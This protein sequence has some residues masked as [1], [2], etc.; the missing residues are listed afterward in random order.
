MYL[1]GDSIIRSH[2]RICKGVLSPDSNP[3]I[4]PPRSFLC[5]LVVRFI[6][7]RCLHAG[8]QETLNEVRDNYWIPRG[9][10]T[11]KTVIKQ[12]VVWRYDARKT[13]KYLGPPPLPKERVKYDHPFSTSR[14]DFTGALKLKVNQ[15]IKKFYVSLFTCTATRAVHLELVDSMSAESFILCLRRFAAQCSLPVKFISDNG[16]NFA[17][18]SHMLSQLYFDKDVQIYLANNKIEWQFISPRAPWQGG[19]YERL[20]GIVKDVNTRPSIRNE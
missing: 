12:C 14:V 11:V 8:T 17:A 7:A 4:L 1:D 19:C 18:T 2:G 6:R 16:A 13:F 15:E 20:I 9:R 5:T 3:V 10:Q